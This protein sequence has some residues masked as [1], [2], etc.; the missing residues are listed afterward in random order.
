[1]ETVEKLRT[2]E[3]QKEYADKCVRAAVLNIEK[4]YEERVGMVI[5]C[6]AGVKEDIAQLQHSCEQMVRFTIEAD[7]KAKRGSQVDMTDLRDAVE[8]RAKLD[9]AVECVQREAFLKRMDRSGLEGFGVGLLGYDDA[10]D[11]DDFLEYAK[12]KKVVPVHIE[13]E[14][15]VNEQTPAGPLEVLT[16]TSTSFSSSMSDSSEED[17]YSS[18]GLDDDYS[19]KPPPRRQADMLVT[20]EVMGKDNSAKGKTGLTASTESDAPNNK[21]GI[22]AGDVF[23]MSIE[24]SGPYL[25]WPSMSDTEFLHLLQTADAMHFSSDRMAGVCEYDESEPDP[26]A[27]GYSSI[28]LFDAVIG[29]IDQYCLYCQRPLYLCTCKCYRGHTRETCGKHNHRREK[30][31]NGFFT[32]RTT[33]EAYDVLRNGSGSPKEK[34]EHWDTF[35]RGLRYYMNSDRIFAIMIDFQ[36]YNSWAKTEWRDKNKHR[37]PRCPICRYRTPTGN[38]AHTLCHSCRSTGKLKTKWKLYLQIGEPFRDRAKK[39]RHMSK[40]KRKAPPREK[41]RKKAAA[42]PQKKKKKKRILASKR[43]ASKNGGKPK[44][45]KKRRLLLNRR[46]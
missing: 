10:K 25:E 45:K 38:T 37:K 35:R 5:A 9:K 44:A 6:I 7:T 16:M 17:S 36:T 31:W 28:G 32:D 19:T 15:G 8:L 23:D 46:K 3:A 1:M 14:N 11:D 41:K 18:S 20:W 43:P 27:G 42:S 24:C 22:S 26:D 12:A 40:A 39:L 34:E 21:F 33:A 29:F 2:I 4:R 30:M 13:I